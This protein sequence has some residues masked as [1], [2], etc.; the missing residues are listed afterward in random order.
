[1]KLFCFILNID[2]TIKYGFY[3]NFIDKAK[4][5]ATYIQFENKPDE[6]NKRKKTLI[7]K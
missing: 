5:L 2:I 6:V 3:V 7:N 1:M 4:E